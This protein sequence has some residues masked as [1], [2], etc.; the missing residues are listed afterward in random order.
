MFSL[1]MWAKITK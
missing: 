1:K